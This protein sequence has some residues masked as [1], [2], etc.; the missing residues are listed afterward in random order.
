M[1]PVL[2]VPDTLPRLTL[3]IIVPFPEPE[4]VL[5]LIQAVLTLA[6]QVPFAVTVTD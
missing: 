3:A 2:V 5:N 1:V 4:F 6:V